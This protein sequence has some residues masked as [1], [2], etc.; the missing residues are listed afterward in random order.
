FLNTGTSNGKQLHTHFGKGPHAAYLICKKFFL[1]KSFNNSPGE[2][3]MPLPV[4]AQFFRRDHFVHYRF[5]CCLI[6]FVVIFG[7]KINILQ[8]Y[9]G[10]MT[11]LWQQGNVNFFMENS[12]YEV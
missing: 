12:C 1:R 4:N 9:I 2:N 8:T 5:L 11:T 7:F 10:K 6:H 3:S